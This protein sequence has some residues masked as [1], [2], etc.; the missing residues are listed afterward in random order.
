VVCG[1]IGAAA[2]RRASEAILAIFEPTIIYSAGF[3][4]GLDPSLKVGDVVWPARVVNASDGSSVVLNNG[5]GV[6]VS[7]ELV[8]SS[9]Q[10]AKLQEAFGAQ[11][12]DMEAAAVAR[13]ADARGVE[14]AVVKV[15]SD[16]SDFEMPPMEQ[17]VDQEGKFSDV[18]FAVFA[19]VR[20]WTWAKIIRL[21]RNSDRASRI[22]SDS[23]GQLTAAANLKSPQLNS[24]ATI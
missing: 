9:S 3:A 16:E 17:F 23:L 20:P 24:S 1:G 18:R 8:A 22:L 13:A 14:F 11:A 7:F 4:G 6:L 19:A 21:A 2:A 5:K 15:I 10:K 12:V